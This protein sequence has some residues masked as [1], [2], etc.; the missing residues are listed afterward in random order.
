MNKDEK[1]FEAKIKSMTSGKG[2]PCQMGIIEKKE[3]ILKTV[4]CNVVNSLKLVETPNYALA[5][6]RVN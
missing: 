4:I 6:K 2:C 5:A 3:T 1:G